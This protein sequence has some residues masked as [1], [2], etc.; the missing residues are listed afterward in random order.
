MEGDFEQFLIMLC[1]ATSNI[2]E[3]YFQLEVA[4]REEHIYRER[5]YCY[6]LYHQLRVVTP[7]GFNYQLDGELDKSGHPLIHDAV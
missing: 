6:E 3:Q 4:E 2:G 1:V 7:D 5:V